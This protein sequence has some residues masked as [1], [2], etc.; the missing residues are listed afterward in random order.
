MEIKLDGTYYEQLGVRPKA[1]LKEI[2]QAYRSLAKQHHPDK[3][4]GCDGE[5]FKVISIAY[6]ILSNSDS[7]KQY[8]ASLRLKKK[9]QTTTSWERFIKM[10]SGVDP[11]IVSVALDFISK[12]KNNRSGVGFFIMH[13]REN[14]DSI[15]EQ[16]CS[17]H[18]LADIT[19]QIYRNIGDKKRKKKGPDIEITLKVS[20][21]ESY[22]QSVKT[23]QIKKYKLCYGCVGRGVVR[24]CGDCRKDAADDIVC[25][26]CLSWEIEESECIRCLNNKCKV[27]GCYI[28]KQQFQIPL[29]HNTMIF[30]NEGDQNPGYDE[31]G[32]VVFHIQT[33]PHPLFVCYK[34]KH[35]VLKKDISLYEWLYGVDFT[36]T[37]LNGE[38][39]R[40]QYNQAIQ[41]PIY[42]IPGKG[43]PST[44]DDPIPGDLLINLVLDHRTINREVI[45]KLAPPIALEGKINPRSNDDLFEA[46]PYLTENETDIINFAFASNQKNEDVDS[47]TVMP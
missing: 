18:A 35:L 36:I 39:I 43:M 14:F 47:I 17:P 6:N 24:F 12:K 11:R 10:L 1:T 7:K 20:L 38:Q 5:V 31:V 23:Y 2:K 8:D 27:R 25:G 32:D 22:Q 16:F 34:H 41:F 46:E 9:D 19:N 42:R 26:N 15:S 29:I 44:K 37:H 40:I 45:Y 3:N 4:S 13:V 33:K 28:V 30:H 21:E